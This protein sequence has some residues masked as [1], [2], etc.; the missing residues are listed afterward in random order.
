MLDIR[1][2][3]DLEDLH[4]EFYTAYCLMVK[5]RPAKARMHL[6]RAKRILEMAKG[7]H[8]EIDDMLVWTNEIIGDLKD[9]WWS[10]DWRY[11]AKFDLEDLI[12]RSAAW[13]DCRDAA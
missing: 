3:M 4:N 1:F 9:R 11:W 6:L 2:D 12:K 10:Q 7:F 5:N 13:C 8:P